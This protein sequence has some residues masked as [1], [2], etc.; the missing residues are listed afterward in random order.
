MTEDGLCLATFLS[1]LAGGFAHCIGMCGVFVIATAGAPDERATGRLLHPE[2]HALFHGG[3]LLS[4][5]LL[6]L[7]AGAAGDLSHAW[8]HTQGALSVA[9]GLLL[10][11]L[12]LGF[13]G[14]VP[15]WRIP[16]PDVLG[17]G[18]GRGR[19]L[20]LT[21]LKSRSEWRPLLVG[22]FVG[23]LPCGLTYYALLPAAMTHSPWAGLAAMVCFGLGT[24]PGLLTLGVFG[25]A[26]GGLF[27]RP[28]FRLAMTK[29][30]AGCMALTGLG[31]VW[32]GVPHL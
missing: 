10:I 3:R 28:Q 21:A 24:I 12:S 23:L 8:P 26:L 5:A 17:A 16:E 27:L 25:N 2:R 32:R 31:L 15:Q 7:I 29:V 20:F 11:G 30:A 22:V 14:V 9:A 6:G 1:G 19:K 18:G 13:A 4:L